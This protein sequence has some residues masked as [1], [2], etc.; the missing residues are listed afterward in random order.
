MRLIRSVVAWP[1]MILLI[2]LSLLLGVWV[3]LS[4]IIE[5]SV[6]CVIAAG[7]GAVD[8]LDPTVADWVQEAMNG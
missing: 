5:F 3:L 7:A 6:Q 4:R 2:V 8:R 1:L